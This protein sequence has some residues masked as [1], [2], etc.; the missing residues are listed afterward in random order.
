MSE[1]SA[2]EVKN[3]IQTEPNSPDNAQLEEVQYVEDKLDKEINLH[4]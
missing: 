1:K 4:T 2:L 3:I